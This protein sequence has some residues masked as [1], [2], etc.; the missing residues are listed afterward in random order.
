MIA[1]SLSTGSNGATAPRQTPDGNADLRRQAYRE[2]NWQRR[3]LPF[4]VGTLITLTIFF[5]AAIA[6]ETHTIQNRMDNTLDIDL[7]PQA[8]SEFRTNGEFLLEANLIERRY[9]AANVAALSRIYL[10]FLGFGTGMVMALIGATFILGKFSEA[11][12]SVDGGGSSI[13]ANLRSGSPGVILAFFGTVLMLSTIYSKTEISVSDRP[14]YLGVGS[15]ADTASQPEALANIPGKRESDGNRSGN[16]SPTAGPTSSTPAPVAAGAKNSALASGVQ[17][18]MASAPSL[19]GRYTLESHS[20]PG[21][22]SIHGHQIQFTGGDGKKRQV[23]LKELDNTHVIFSIVELEGGHQ[24][25]DGYLTPPHN[26]IVGQTSYHGSY[27][28]HPW[29]FIATRAREE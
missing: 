2:S 28:T 9:R 27:E 10:V 4:L 8:S 1:D 23:A 21:I 5:C 25:F 15:T 16:A 14:V 3:L 13:K 12:T 11:E 6:W 22:L 19:D 26:D 7:R 18:V 17:L 24:D 20:G 29:G